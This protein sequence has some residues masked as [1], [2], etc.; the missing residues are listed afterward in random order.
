M[1][2]RDHVVGVQQEEVFSPPMN[3]GF[4]SALREA[5]DVKATFVG[6]DHVNDYCGSLMDINLCYGGGTGYHAYGKVGWFRRARV[7]VA[8]LDQSSAGQVGGTPNITTWKRLDDRKFSKEDAQL[9]YSKAEDVLSTARTFAYRND[10]CFPW[11]TLKYRQGRCFF[12][13]ALLFTGVCT[14]LSGLFFLLGFSVS[15]CRSKNSRAAYRLVK[16][17]IKFKIET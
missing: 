9:L 10:C 1:L 6:H 16:S 15:R 7:V 2:Y 5:G 13:N 4:F 17:D 11:N 12:W 8:S 14:L 3:S